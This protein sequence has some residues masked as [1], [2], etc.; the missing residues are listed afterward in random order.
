MYLQAYMGKETFL[1]S[2]QIRKF[3]SSFRN[4]KS[5]NFFR[6]P[7]R[8]SALYD[9]ISLFLNSAALSFSSFRFGKSFQWFA[10]FFSKFKFIFI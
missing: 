2:L 10:I 6:V 5:A 1:K 9:L 7:V 8:K 3:L 4:P